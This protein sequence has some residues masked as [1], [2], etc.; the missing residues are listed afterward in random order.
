MAKEEGKNSRGE[1]SD[2][3]GLAEKIPS[4]TIKAQLVLISL[5]SPFSAIDSSLPCFLS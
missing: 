1:H 5:F 4:N 2:M 3:A